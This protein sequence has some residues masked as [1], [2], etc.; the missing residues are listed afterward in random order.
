[1]GEKDRIVLFHANNQNI[2]TKTKF[3]FT[4]R[5]LNYGE[6]QLLHLARVISLLTFVKLLSLSKVDMS[7]EGA[8]V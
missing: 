8:A 6:T 3:K 4:N 2:G 5:T 1:M 7:T